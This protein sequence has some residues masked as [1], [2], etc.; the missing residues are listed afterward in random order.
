MKTFQFKTLSLCLL[1]TSAMSF[2]TL[3]HA[4]VPASWTFNDVLSQNKRSQISQY[5][6]VGQGEQWNNAVYK[7]KYNTDPNTHLLVTYNDKP[8]YR[9]TLDGT[10]LLSFPLP[11]EK[12]GFHRL[13][14]IVENRETTSKEN[15]CAEPP[16]YI[17]SLEQAEISYQPHRSQL[18]LSELPDALYNPKLTSKTPLRAVFDYNTKSITERNILA[19]L[20]VGWEHARQIQWF[21]PEQ[22]TEQPADYRINIKQVPNLTTAPVKL[23]YVQGIPTLSI[24]Y[25]TAEQLEAVARVLL[26]PKFNNQLT[27]DSAS[28]TSSVSEPEWATAR[29]FNTLADF[30]IQDFRIGLDKYNFSLAF[31]SVWEPS[32]SLSGIISLRSQTGLLEG[33]SISAWINDQLAGNIQL[34]Y[35]EEKP[36]DRQ[37]NIL[38]AKV[39]VKPNYNLHLENSI[40]ANSQCL[41]AAHGAVWVNTEKSQLTLPYTL[42]IG[43]M[44]ASSSLAATPKIAVS[45]DPGSLG[46]AVTAMQ[47]A[48]DML[49]TNAPVKLQISTFN[50]AAPEKVNIRIDAATYQQLV[51]QHENILYAP[52]AQNGFFAVFTNDNV[53]FITSNELGANTFNQY[54]SGIQSEIPNNVGQIF[55]S[56]EGQLHILENISPVKTQQ[57]VIKQSNSFLWIMLGLFAIVVIML[58]LLWRKRKNDTKKDD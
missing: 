20:V 49:L 40:I 29:T 36:L 34:A 3:S 25:S 14:F 17:S 37:F 47:S 55:V 22:K 1:A 9:T 42:K 54:W 13:D 23:S 8:I 52:T 48:K 21:R 2:M 35:L 33:S 50:P 12:S 46:M 45:G 43:V 24:E 41:P 31:P 56:S 16:I 32:D 30:G 39:E 27:G 4:A 51:K 53:H 18:R 19:R 11:V 38:G 15:M 26:Q 7:A 44:S 57:A 5:F 28:I 6:Y 58:L 10:G